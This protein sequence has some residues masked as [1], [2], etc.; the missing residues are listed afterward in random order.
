MTA[1]ASTSASSS[2]TTMA[3]MRAPLSGNVGPDD[4]HTEV[5]SVP[6]Q[7]YDGRPYLV[8]QGAGGPPLLAR[9]VDVHVHE[10]ALGS[11]LRAGSLRIALEQPDPVD[12]RRG[13]DPVHDHAQVDGLGVA[14]L[15]EVATAD[16]GHHP[17]R[18]QRPDVGADRLGQM[19]V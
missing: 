16:L 6:Q 7:G 12:D 17:D 15:A 8:G 19:S 14:D 3:P 11:R 5:R 1:A 13:T 4:P 18:R 9:V 2:T 10:P